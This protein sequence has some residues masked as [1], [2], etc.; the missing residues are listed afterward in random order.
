MSGMGDYKGDRP[1]QVVRALGSMYKDFDMLQATVF[2]PERA[3]KE[4]NSDYS[5]TTELADILQREANTPFRVGH[6]FAS[7][8]VTYGRSHGLKP[9]EIP[10]N[11]AQKLFAEAWKAFG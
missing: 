3:L 4:V 6:H 7:H 8:V 11:E 9:A 1:L 5:M 10:Y 2:D